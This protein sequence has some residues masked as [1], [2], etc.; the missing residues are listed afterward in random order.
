MGLD[1]KRKKAPAE[2]GAGSGNRWISGRAV[3]LQ[4]VVDRQVSFVGE[5]IF[6]KHERPVDL[7]LQG[8]DAEACSAGVVEGVEVAALKVNESAADAPVQVVVPRGRIGSGTGEDHQ[9]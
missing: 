2:P 1:P 9:Q 8:T 3:G 7:P 5:G 6:Q 4:G